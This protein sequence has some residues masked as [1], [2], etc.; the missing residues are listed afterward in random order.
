MAAEPCSCFR[1]RKATNP[2]TTGMA[3]GLQK[4]SSANTR[5]LFPDGR[6]DDAGAAGPG[7]EQ[8]PAGMVGGEFPDHGGGGGKRQCPEESTAIGR[9]LGGDNG[10]E[11]PFVG[12]EERIEAEQL[13]SG[14]HGRQDG[15]G[16]FLQP[17][18]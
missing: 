1:F 6:M 12:D 11:D 2:V 15:Q 9:D 8:E 14:G 5:Q 10:Q 18:A 16:R 3:R 13:T 17:D 4:F 7:P